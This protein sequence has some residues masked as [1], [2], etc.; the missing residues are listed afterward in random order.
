MDVFGAFISIEPGESR[1][2]VFEYLL[3]ERV[4]D[5][6][7]SGDYTLNWIKQVGAKNH[8]LTLDL[9]FDKKVTNASRPE[10]ISEW[11]DEIYRLNTVLSQDLMF[12]VAL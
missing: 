11:G 10:D 12:D 2:L 1:E 8:Q 9:D 3:S 4:V 6:I 7:K 5:L